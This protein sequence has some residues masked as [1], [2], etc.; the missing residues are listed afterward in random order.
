[1]YDGLQKQTE[2]RVH[3]VLQLLTRPLM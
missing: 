3:P 1:V 2:P